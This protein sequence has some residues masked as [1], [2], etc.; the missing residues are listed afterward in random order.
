MILR[1]SIDFISM[2]EF[3]RTF[4]CS[5]TYRPHFSVPHKL[6]FIMKICVLW[7]CCCSLQSKVL[8]V[9]PLSFK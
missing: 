3:E 4:F 7:Y 6:D 1:F 8:K 5:I 2:D 9:I